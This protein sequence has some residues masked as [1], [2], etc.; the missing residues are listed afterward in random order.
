MHNLWDVFLDRLILLMILLPLIGAWIVLIVAGFGPEAARRSALV[1]VLITFSLATVMVAGY[2]P[3]RTFDDGSPRV[4]QMESN[5]RWLAERSLQS[6][7]QEGTQGRG[8]VVLT[9]V[10]RGTDVRFAVG[11]DGISLWPIALTALLAI[12][13]V[14]AGWDGGADRP[15]SFYALL[16][17]LESGLIGVFAAL[18]V[19][20]F[21][22]FL[23]LSLIPAVFLIGWWGGYRRRAVVHRLLLFN[24]AG[25][26]LILL[27][28]IAV[29]VSFSWMYAIEFQSQPRLT[30][31]MAGLT[32]G[33]HAMLEHEQLDAARRY[34]QRVSPWIFLSLSAGLAI[35]LPLAPFH[36]WLAATNDEAPRSVRLLLT[37]V[38]SIVGC[39]GFLR[40]VIPL[41]PE[42]SIRAAELIGGLALLST[43]F[44]ALLM[45]AQSDWKRLAACWTTATMGLCL[46]GV[47]SLTAVG[48]TGGLLQLV[49]HGLSMGLL[50][51]LIGALER[52][53]HSTAIDEFGGLAGRSPLLAG[54]FVFAVASLIGVPGLNV[55]AGQLLLLLGLFGTAP[56][57]AVAGML[58]LLLGTWAF[59][60]STAK[61]V[62]GKRRLPRPDASQPPCSAD[63]DSRELAG[64]LPLVL[65]IAWIGL[66]PQ[67]FIDRIEPSLQQLLNRYRVESSE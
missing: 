11:V 41:F 35:K 65:V 62:F 48:V 57:L 45:P 44:A 27:G 32:E 49:N 18:D 16:L 5:L 42:I 10:I 37:A 34:W 60:G 53:Y 17:V 6:V 63:L 9:Q 40:L 2:D 23:E 25:S 56:M 55:F 30:F 50:L 14:L 21:Y 13:A 1:N 39:Y 59:V 7:R 36:S 64:L 28:V 4:I 66:A 33:I 19:V 3:H 29:V 8:E 38:A 43:L 46:A 67:F 58:A 24:L 20:L 61:M 15:A 12:P 52:R 54:L 26:L 31:S 47:F 51:L 22:V